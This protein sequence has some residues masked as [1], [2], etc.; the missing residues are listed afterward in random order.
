MLPSS[1]RFWPTVLPA[2]AEAAKRG[3]DRA[4][5]DAVLPSHPAAAVR[6]Q[7][8][9]GVDARTAAAARG[10]SSVLTMRPSRFGAR[11]IPREAFRR[12]S[13]GLVAV[14]RAAFPRRRLPS[15]GASG[16][17]VDGDRRRRARPHARLQLLRAID[18]DRLHGDGAAA[19]STTSIATR[20][21]TRGCTWS[22]ATIASP[23]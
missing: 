9:R 2:Y 15:G 14:A 6:H 18:G 8:R 13:A 23:T 7:C 20:R 22:F 10:A 19:S 3:I 21:A 1:A 5:R 4:L 16:H 11:W 17:P 12:A